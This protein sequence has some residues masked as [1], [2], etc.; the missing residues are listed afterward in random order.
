MKMAKKMLPK[1]PLPGAGKTGWPWI[2]SPDP[3]SEFMP[4]GSR[5]PKISIVTPSF[6]QAAYL[7]ETIRS[8]LLQDYPNLEY[9]I[10]DGGSTDDSVEIIKK[11]KP[12]LTYWVSEKDNGQSHAINKGFMKASGLIGGWL[13]SDDL[14]LPGA[15]RAIAVEYVENNNEISV[16]SGKTRVT[17]GKLVFK[18]QYA[19]EEYSVEK[20]IQFC[21]VPQASTFFS[22]PLYRRLGGVNEKLD[23]AFDYDLWLRASKITDIEVISDELAI[24]RQ[25]DQIKTKVNN[26]RSVREAIQVVFKSYRKVPANWIKLF[27][28]G[29]ILKYRHGD[30]KLRNLLV[31]YLYQFCVDTSMIYVKWRGWQA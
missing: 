21:I 24:W 12:W 4:D 11:Y 22:M 23:M 18:R 26:K 31:N 10:I 8:V 20:L 27:W 2:E 25:H 14:Y 9:I 1:L 19:I 3:I 13:N 16:I 28:K 15:L 7:E 6:N 5:W 17:D 30:K 29:R